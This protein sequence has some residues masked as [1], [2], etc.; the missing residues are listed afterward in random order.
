MEICGSDGLRI[1]IKIIGIFLIA[2]ILIICIKEYYEATKS[3]KEDEIKKAQKSLY[4]KMAIVVYIFL[5]PIIM[6]AVSKL[7][8]KPK[9]YSCLFGNQN[10]NISIKVDE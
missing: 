9:I 1:F 2:A 4:K 10:E 5:I 6:L 3:K 7:L 8:N